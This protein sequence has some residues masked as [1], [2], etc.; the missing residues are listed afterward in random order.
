MDPAARGGIGRQIDLPTGQCPLSYVREELVLPSRK[1]SEKLVGIILDEDVL[2]W[3]AYSPDLNPIE[4]LWS[5]LKRR[6]GRTQSS[7]RNM[8]DLKTVAHSIWLDVSQQVCTNLVASMPKR[9][10]QVIRNN[11]RTVGIC[12]D[13]YT[14]N[15]FLEAQ[16]QSMQTCCL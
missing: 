16:R 15:T 11:N 12:Y 13:S 6:I 1:W 14:K 2:E 3:P 7:V 8:D 4:N 5:I 9:I 10:E